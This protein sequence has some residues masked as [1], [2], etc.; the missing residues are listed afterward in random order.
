[1]LSRKPHLDLSKIEE[2]PLLPYSS[3]FIAPPEEIAAILD[4][5]A[6]VKLAGGSGKKWGLHS[7]QIFTVL[8]E[9]GDENNSTGYPLN[10]LDIP[11]SK[12]SLSIHGRMV[13]A[14]QFHPTVLQ[15]KRAD[16]ANLIVSNGYEFCMETSRTRTASDINRG[17]G[18][19]SYEGRLQLLE[20]LQAS[21]MGF[22]LW[23]DLRAIK[24]LSTCT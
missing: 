4:K 19:I 18:L 9:P 24:K 14:C 3:S 13:D 20:D 1:M 12:L 11:L 6:I 7:T 5:I 22:V 2:P 21:S 8:V 16:I 15:E 17:G 23:V 10:M